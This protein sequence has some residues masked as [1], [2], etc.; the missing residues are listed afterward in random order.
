MVKC[1]RRFFSIMFVVMIPCAHHAVF[2]E[3]SPSEADDI[4]NPT[5]HSTVSEVRLV[6]FATDEHNHN[7]QELK[8]D[9]F[10]VIDNE[11]VIRDFR[12]FTRSDTT[13]LNVVVLIDSS[14]SVLPRLQTEITDAVQLISRSSSGPSDGLSV[15]SFSGLGTH[16]VCSEDCRDLPTPR[17]LSLPRGG[18]TPL[19]DALETAATLLAKR[20]RPDVWPVVI[21]FSDG[22][23]TISKISRREV[24]DKIL[25][26]GAQIY[27]VDVS[28]SGSPSNGSAVLQ[29]LADDSG[30]RY[31]RISDGPSSI[32][33]HVMDDL[34]SARV[35]T[36][37]YPG[38]DSD[39]HSI[40]ILPS[41][42]LNLKF[43]S[44]CGYYHDSRHIASQEK[45]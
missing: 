44:R 43:H 19:F 1:F 28:G 37:V 21:L 35:V 22:D 5:Y 6:F 34:H 11:R 7:V 20:S 42:N 38:P 25:S 8:K 31:L 18:A 15:L 24:L 23:D 12:G 39:F 13:N 26:I 27:A 32:L 36:Y 29:N 4:T 30:G 45:P 10:A 2:A 40:R 41:R 14:E 3:P 33:D 17:I 9:D 16:V